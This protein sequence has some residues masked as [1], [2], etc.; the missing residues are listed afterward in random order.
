MNHTDDTIEMLWPDQDAKHHVHI[1]EQVRIEAERLRRKA[2]NDFMRVLFAA[3]AAG[4][5]QLVRAVRNITTRPAARD[6]GDTTACR[7]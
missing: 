3:L 1:Y 5:R 6:A 4:P 7:C 2:I